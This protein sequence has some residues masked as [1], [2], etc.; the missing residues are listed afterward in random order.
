MHERNY[1]Y[2]ILRNRECGTFFTTNSDEDPT[3]L[4]DGT[5]AYT[6]VGY[7]DT[8]AEAQI[9]IYGRSYTDSKE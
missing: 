4:I 3:R 8:I 9:R 1:K 2:V 7:A 5:V 6:I